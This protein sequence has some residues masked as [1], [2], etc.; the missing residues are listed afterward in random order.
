MTA[1]PTEIVAPPP[2]RKMNILFGLTLIGLLIFLWIVLGVVTPSFWTPLNISNLLRQGAMTAI[3]ALGQTFVIITA[4]IDLSV[5]AI[6]GFCTVII[7]WL[8]QAGVP[9]WGAIVLTLLIGMAIGAF[10]GFGI[11][12]MGLP[13]FIITLATLTSLRGIGLLITNGSTINITNENFSNF[14]RADLFSIPSLFWMVILVAVPSFIFLHLSRWGRYLFAVGSNAEAAR[15]SGVNVKGM[16]YLA[17][18]LSASFAAFVGVLLASRIAIGNATQA[19][20]WELQAIASSV[21]GGTSLFGAVG[22]V[23]GPLIGAFILA[24][25][26]NGANL[27]NVNSFWQRIITGLLII[28]IVF[29]DQLRRRRSN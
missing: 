21:I 7:A 24:T 27:L 5:G 15:L 26:N 25:I 8:L 2:R 9:V 1:T 16:I 6:V 18:I 10:H 29:F 22:S 11:V 13:P 17:Y 14:A 19:D 28:V 12:H 4:G 23:H 20:G 3:L